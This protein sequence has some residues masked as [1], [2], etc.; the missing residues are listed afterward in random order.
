[1][2]GDD[3]APRRE[4]NPR[5]VPRLH[6]RLHEEVGARRTPT[7]RDDEVGPAPA[8]AVG[9]RGSCMR[10]RARLGLADVERGS[11]RVGWGR[12]W[13]SMLELV[14]FVGSSREAERSARAR[15]ALRHHSA[16]LGGPPVEATIEP[17][18]RPRNRAAPQAPRR[19]LETRCRVARSTV[20]RAPPRQRARRA[21]ARAR[22]RATPWCP[23][24]PHGAR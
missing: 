20:R 22:S 4:G 11:A 18:M 19:F 7:P 5:V 21:G 6:H 24:P 12:S 14:P 16:G 17:F 1:M 10:V 15:R 2:L 8:R 23:W 3:V 9:S 13:S